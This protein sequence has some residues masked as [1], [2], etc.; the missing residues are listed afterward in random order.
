VPDHRDVAQAA[1]RLLDV[2]L[3]LITSLN[4]RGGGD[5]RE[6]RIGDARACDPATLRAMRS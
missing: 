3:E 4:G 1:G 2:R 6:E 5:E